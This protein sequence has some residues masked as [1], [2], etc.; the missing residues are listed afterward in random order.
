MTNARDHA[1]DAPSPRSV[2]VVLGTR[3]EI[4]KLAG[5]VSL[6]GP[7]ARLV[8]SGQHYSDTLSRIFLDDLGLPEPD[9]HLA[10]GG[11]T[12]GQQIARATG[13]LDTHFAEDRPA[14]VVVQGDTNT[15]LA[16]ALAAN[17]N[18]VPLVHVEAG[19]RSGDRAMPEEHNRVVTDHLADLLL[20]PTNV[21]RDNL[22]R[23]G[24][25]PARIV[26]TGNTVVEAVTR[27]LPD[28]DRRGA[29]REALGLGAPHS[30]ALA[31]FHRPENVD[32]AGAF[33]SIL[34]E[35][36][37]LPIDVVLP[38]HPRARKRAEAYGLTATLDRLHVIEPLGYAD[39][40]ALAA[41]AAV[42]VSDSGGVQEE[43]SVL[44]RPLVVVRRSTERPEVLGTFAH[45]VGPGPAI[46]A[47][48][49][50]L[51]DDLDGVLAELA[52]LPSPYGDGTASQRSHDAILELV[53]GSA[54]VAPA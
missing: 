4:V 53:R 28:A 16:G 11:E 51:L 41:E 8:H 22:L 24:V 9:V 7:A 31:T 27:A 14:A 42:L 5:I 21:A 45:L 43:V 23:E 18:D 37:A 20:A 54:A 39:F 19:L 33:G 1:A 48:V 30:Y 15:V 35:L 29:V 3:P 12:R 38:L 44:K 36:E 32:D 25:D 10:V 13:A 26:V 34:E 17:A 6:L 52:E 40:L 46:G 47:T 49:S 50:T 2:A